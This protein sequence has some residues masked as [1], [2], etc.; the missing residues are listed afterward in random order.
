MELQV[1]EAEH[2][3]IRRSGSLSGS[4]TH[5]SCHMAKAQH[6]RETDEGDERE[7]NDTIALAELR[8]GPCA[9]NLIFGHASELDENYCFGGHRTA[10]EPVATDD[11]PVAP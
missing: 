6:E 1:L 2:H 3:L 8:S 11:D 9:V 5:L 4:A 7:Q 10:I